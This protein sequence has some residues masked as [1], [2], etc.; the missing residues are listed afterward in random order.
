MD[1]VL[2]IIRQIKK[3]FNFILLYPFKCFI[4]SRFY[5]VHHNSTVVHVYNIHHTKII[6]LL[7][8]YVQTF[9]GRVHHQNS[10]ETTGEIF[11][12]L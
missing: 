7:E 4:F 1:F 2:L 9:I 11:A 8:L 10:V 6:Q 5:S 12:S 3:I